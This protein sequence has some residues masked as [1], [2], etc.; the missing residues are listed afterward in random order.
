MIESGPGEPIHEITAIREHLGH[1][2]KGQTAVV[3]DILTAFL[4][5]GHV[6]LEG[7]PG[8]A[9][10]LVVRCLAQLL[11]Q[12]FS[13]I[14]LT[15]DLMPADVTGVNVFD[16]NT[17]TF[18]FRPGPVF[19]DILLADEINR[20]PAKTQSAM[21]EA[22]QEKQVTIDGTSHPLSE[23][24]TVIATQNPLEYEGTYPL[25]EAQLDRF[26]MKVI[27]DYPDEATELEV[28]TRMHEL[29]ADA[30]A[31]HRLLSAVTD[32]TAI[33]ALRARVHQIG[34]DEAV[35][36]Y[37]LGLVRKSR[38]LSTSSTG[39]SPRAGVML[40]QAAK[41]RALLAGYSYTRPEEVQAVA[42]PVL[43][44]RLI[45]TPEAQIE[46]LTPDDCIQTLIKQVPIPR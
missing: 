37:A 22:M 33:A 34:V 35:L 41:A 40:I 1:I 21:L 16:P 12:R 4:A 29:G 46:G 5:G 30:A 8:V 23:S 24:F 18:S 25:P 9:K 31:P 7:V 15:P 43:R 13:R 11:G 27:V 42:F 6:L 38:E 17:A 44:H 14:Q 45:L 26:A 2:I 32:G 36:R 10:T 39:A 3:D 20:A 19:T 28:L